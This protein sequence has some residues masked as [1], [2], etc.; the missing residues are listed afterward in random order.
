MADNSQEGKAEILLKA[1]VVLQTR[2]T[3]AFNERW[4]YAAKNYRTAF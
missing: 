4:H 1:M 2:K 3:Y